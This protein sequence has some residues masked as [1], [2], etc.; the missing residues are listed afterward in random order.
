MGIKPKT[1]NDDVK[2][3][4][5]GESKTIK[6]TETVD[7]PTNEL[8][9]TP[10]EATP[11]AST[12]STA[13]SNNQQFSER[14]A[15]KGLSGLELG[16]GSFP[17]IR[18]MNDGEF[19]DSDENEMGTSFT[20]KLINSK[21]SYLF[22]QKNNSDSDVYYSYD[23]VNLTTTTDGGSSTVEELKI[24]WKEDGWDL[25]R[26]DY[27]ECVVIMDDPDSEIVDEM[28]IL[29]IPPSS[30]RKLAGVIAGLEFKG[31]DPSTVSFNCFVGKKRKSG[32]NTYYPW[33]F[34]AVT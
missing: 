9:E 5:H 32:T 8:S 15:E 10:V 6:D 29:S 20:C 33:A 27:L 11:Q 31:I 13:T 34:K 23:A 26:K 19:A 14:M 3:E 24:E 16:F 17:I 2:E 18:L 21:P 30:R 22:K 25:E 4:N 7:S 28:Y 1:A 12:I